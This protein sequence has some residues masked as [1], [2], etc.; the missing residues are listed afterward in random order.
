MNEGPAWE[1]SKENV[2]P[3]K[4]GRS[5]KGLQ[6]SL[7]HIHNTAQKGTNSIFEEELAGEQTPSSILDVYVRYFKWTRDEFPSNAAKSMEI[8]ERCTAQL[9]AASELKNDMRFVKMWIEYVSQRLRLNYM[10][11]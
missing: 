8:L 9:S 2:L 3:V 10:A 7:N 1:T 11:N 5:T 6:N 4:R